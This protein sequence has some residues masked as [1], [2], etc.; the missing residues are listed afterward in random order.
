MTATLLKKYRSMIQ[1]ASEKIVSALELTA[2]PML[3]PLPALV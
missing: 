3:V 1:P 2:A